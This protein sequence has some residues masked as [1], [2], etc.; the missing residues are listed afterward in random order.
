MI[1]L[2]WSYLIG[3]LETAAGTIDFT[4]SVLNNTILYKW[5][6]LTRKSCQSQNEKCFLSIDIGT[7]VG[8]NVMYWKYLYNTLLILKIGINICFIR[9]TLTT[10][11]NGFVWVQIKDSTN[12]HGDG[13]IWRIFPLYKLL[14]KKI[15]EEDFE[16]YYFNISHFNIDLIRMNSDDILLQR[17]LKKYKGTYKTLSSVFRH[18][19]SWGTS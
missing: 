19:L 4:S 18:L 11:S 6:L 2:N 1:I 12:F 10:F 17:S 13:I 5:N 15:I 7:N 16:L 9:E 14:E 8:N 3:Y